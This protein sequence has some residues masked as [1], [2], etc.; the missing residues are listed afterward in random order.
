MGQAEPWRLD[1]LPARQGFRDLAGVRGMESFARAR[2]VRFLRVTM[3][4]APGQL[5]APSGWA[6]TFSVGPAAGYSR[7]L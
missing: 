5:P 1:L 2:G 7:R 6:K 4:T 3:P